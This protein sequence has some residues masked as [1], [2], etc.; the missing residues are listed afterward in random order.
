MVTQY[1]K[2]TEN[3]RTSVKKDS[4]KK[5][6]NVFCKVKSTFL[7]MLIYKK[8]LTGQSYS[9]TSFL[10]FW[11]EETLSFNHIFTVTESIYCS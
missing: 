9:G 11:Q 8:S 1:L 10:E 5:Q 4:F 6:P 7:S 2:G 3:S